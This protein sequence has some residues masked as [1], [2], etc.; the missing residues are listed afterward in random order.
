[1]EEID[2]KGNNLLARKTVGHYGSISKALQEMAELTRVGE[3]VDPPHSRRS[4]L[5]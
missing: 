1:M 2:I 3:A 5:H 4:T